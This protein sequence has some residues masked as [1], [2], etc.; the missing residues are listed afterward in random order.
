LGR[1]R[2]LARVFSVALLL[3]WLAVD[4]LLRPVRTRRQGAERIHLCCRRIL[5]ALG[6]SWNASGET[7]KSGAVVCNHLSYL[8]ILVFA[9]HRP[10]IMVAKSEVSEWPLIGW[11]TR[12]AGT[13][14]VVR[15]GGPTT[16]PAVNQAMAEAF[17]SGLPVLFF[18]EGTTTDGSSVLPFK[19]GLLHSV[20]NEAAPLHV[21]T[22]EYSNAAACWWGDDLL[23]PHILQVASRNDLHAELHFG[24]AVLGR[25]D[26]FEL[27]AAA[28]EEIIQLRERS[29]T[30]QIA[31]AH[32]HEDLLHGPVEGL[33]AFD[34]HGCVLR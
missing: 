19:R 8:D 30:Q 9:A 16:Y 17:R 32:L 24:S 18:P 31:L 23:L 10:F 1:L 27:A 34:G 2:S 13:V 11:L 26:R 33:G 6:V 29:T 7:P 5:R 12:Q 15:G 14:F 21:S 20:L 22:L 28:R 3:L 25:E 4:F